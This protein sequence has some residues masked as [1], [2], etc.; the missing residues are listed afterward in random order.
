VSEPP[1]NLFRF[2]AQWA[3]HAED[4]GL[5]IWIDMGIDNEPLQSWLISWSRVSEFADWLRAQKPERC[6]PFS[7][8]LTAA[9]LAPHRKLKVIP[10]I[11]ALLGVTQMGVAHWCRAHS[12]PTEDQARRIAAFLG[13][14]ERDTL[15]D[16]GDE[17]AERARRA[18]WGRR[19]EEAKPA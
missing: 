18:R 5:R 17:L 6:K 15:A 8:R 10:K 3:V 14:D 1:E 13:W 7:S 9:C 12:L 16:L 4:K 11:A 19:R 2:S